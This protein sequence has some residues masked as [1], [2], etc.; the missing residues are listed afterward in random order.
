MPSEVP[1]TSSED[2]RR[3]NAPHTDQVQRPVQGKDRDGTKL[4]GVQVVAAI[5]VALLF[6]NGT[7]DPLTLLTIF[8][9]LF[10]YHTTEER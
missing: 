8:V 9:L 10:A 3:G 5:I 1:E 2:H 6:F 7:V 4:V